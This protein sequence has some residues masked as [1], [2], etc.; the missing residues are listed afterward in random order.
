MKANWR[1]YLPEDLYYTYEHIDYSEE[2]EVVDDDIEL[3]ET[4]EKETKKINK[5]FAKMLNPNFKEGK[6]LSVKKVLPRHTRNS[7]GKLRQFRGETICKVYIKGQGPPESQD[8]ISIGTTFWPFSKTKNKICKDGL[9][10][11]I[12]KP[13]APNLAIARNVARG[14]AEKNLIERMAKRLHCEINQLCSYKKEEAWEQMKNESAN[15]SKNYNGISKE[16][17]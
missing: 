7:R 10:R 8:A 3:H 1:K 15:Y 11:K 5:Q 2:Y 13:C 17:L 16:K 6:T 9:L 4:W 14:R 12:T